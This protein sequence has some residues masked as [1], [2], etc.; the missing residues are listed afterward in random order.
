MTALLVGIYELHQA[1][2]VT[3][4]R[5]RPTAAG[6]DS[7]PFTGSPFSVHT[8]SISVSSQSVRC[9]LCNGHQLWESVWVF[10][11]ECELIQYL[12]LCVC[13]ISECPQRNNLLLLAS[14]WTPLCFL[15]PNQISHDVAC[16]HDERPRPRCPFRPDDGHRG[17]SRKRELPD[18]SW[19]RCLTVDNL[20]A[21]VTFWVLFR[22]LSSY[23][24][25]F[26]KRMGPAL[27]LC[28]TLRWKVIIFFLSHPRQ[29]DRLIRKD[30]VILNSL[31]HKEIFLHQSG[32]ADVY[33]ILISLL[34]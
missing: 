23:F 7:D 30:I 11:W 6:G 10:F 18:R 5:P 2:Y 21:V 4:G 16:W 26:L 17:I 20:L 12:C 25:P 3:A 28:L 33:F 13:V 22:A 27:C 34:V 29:T 1:A 8:Y 32:P 31:S 19:Q 24:Y 15:Q 14:Q 9:F